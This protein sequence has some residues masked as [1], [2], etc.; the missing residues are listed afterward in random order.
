MSMEQMDLMEPR[1]IPAGCTKKEYRRSYAS[2]ELY[3]NLKTLAIW[4]Y[5]MAGI[6]ALV[7]PVDGI[8]ML[9]MLLIMHLKRV[10]WPVIGMMINAGLGC[11][12]SLIGGGGITG[13][14]WF[15]LGF[16]C[17]GVFKKMDGEYEELTAN[18][19]NL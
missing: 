13:W 18:R 11:L 17:M 4:G 7:S 16:A 19:V 12:F 9:A 8:F 3:K 10:K 2:P 5:V 6:T 1:R 15:I 14:F